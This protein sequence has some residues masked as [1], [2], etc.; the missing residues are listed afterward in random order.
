MSPTTLST[1]P[2]ELR[3][4]ITKYLNYDD[5]WSLKQTS[6]LFY[7]VVEIPTIQSFLACPSGPSLRILEDWAIIPLGCEACHY[8]KHILP[9]ERFSRFQ[10]HLTAA[11]QHALNFDY[12]TWKPE[13][14]YCLECGVREHHY[15]GGK[16]IYVGFSSPGFENEAAMSCQHCG[17]LIDYDLSHLQDCQTCGSPPWTVTRDRRS[18]MQDPAEPK[19]RAYQWKQLGPVLA[20][21]GEGLRQKKHTFHTDVPT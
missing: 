15:S 6:S 5:A 20:L 21:I 17:N 12:A 11:R 10:R 4:E 9:K 16:W 1:I 2:E 13:K 8:C 14:H 7:R 19:R 3:Q 18:S